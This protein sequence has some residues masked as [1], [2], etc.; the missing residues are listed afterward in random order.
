[1]VRGGLVRSAAYWWREHE[2]R[3]DSSRIG[4]AQQAITD[5]GQARHQSGRLH[6]Q[7]HAA[8]GPLLFN[9]FENDGREVVDLRL[10]GFLAED[11]PRLEDE[12]EISQIAVA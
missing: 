2:H 3:R 10:E 7:G 8:E 4:Q 9:A 12:I 11:S 1:M 6:P 5:S